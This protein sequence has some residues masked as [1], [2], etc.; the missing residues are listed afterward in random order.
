MTEQ[1][2]PGDPKAAERAA[3]GDLEA[4]V[5]ERTAEL[6]AALAQKTA[7]LHEVDHRVKNNLQLIASL[8]LLQTR[9]ASDPAVKKALG[10]LLDRITAVA[11]VHRRLFQSDDVAMFDFSAFLHDLADD[12]LGAAG[13][14]DIKILLDAEPARVPASLATSLALVVN[15][16]LINAITHAF[17]DGRGGEI[18]I[19]VRRKHDIL[20][21]EIADNGVGMPCAPDSSPDS[22]GGNGAQATGFGLTIVDLLG[23]QLRAKIDR[24]DQGPGVGVT[25]EL[26]L[27]G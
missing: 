2:N 25:L 11:T 6:R 27:D 21:I 16:L 15:E 7:L 22:A 5:A 19:G 8:L 23:R 4:V 13:R 26:P 24:R 9:R 1:M 17:P 12:A 14:S 10:S 20:R 18:T 3:Q